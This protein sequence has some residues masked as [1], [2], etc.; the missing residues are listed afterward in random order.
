M[1]CPNC[2]HEIDLKAED[3]PTRAAI[4][5]VMRASEVRMSPS[6]LSEVLDEPIG[7]VAYH[8]KMLHEAKVLK[9]AGSRPVRG[10]TEHFYRVV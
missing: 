2:G 1:K 3:H 4:M 8:V 9:R 10:A 7:N 6:Q 5:R